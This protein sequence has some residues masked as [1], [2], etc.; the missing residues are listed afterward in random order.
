[1]HWLGLV[2]RADEAAR[3][4]AYGRAFLGQAPWP[5]PAEPEDKIILKMAL[6]LMDHPKVSRIEFSGGA[7]RQ[8]G[9]GW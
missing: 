7:I 8:L 6:L 9:F 5:T 1:M 2:D 4:T 3:L